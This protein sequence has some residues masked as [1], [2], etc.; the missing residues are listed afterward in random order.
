[1]KKIIF[2]FIFLCIFNASFANIFGLDEKSWTTE[3]NRSLC[4]FIRSQKLMNDATKI[5]NDDSAIIKSPASKVL[6]DRYRNA[7]DSAKLV[8][9]STLDKLHPAF[10]K[11]YEKY[12]LG[13]QTRI[14]SLSQSGTIKQAFTAHELINDFSTWYNTSKKSWQIPKG[15]VANC[16]KNL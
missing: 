10:F 2:A 15:E 12:K 13:I 6:L 11:N 14:H 8:E 1:M 16:R 7:L 4:N 9:K 3:D 5:L